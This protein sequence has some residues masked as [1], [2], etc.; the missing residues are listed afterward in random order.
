MAE[1]L[2]L[3]LDPCAGKS[4][5]LPSNPTFQSFKKL[6]D[7]TNKSNGFLL[8]N[9][10]CSKSIFIRLGRREGKKKNHN[11]TLEKLSPKGWWHRGRR[12]GPPRAPSHRGA[13]RGGSG[14]GA[15]ALTPLS[16]QR[17]G[18]RTFL[19]EAAVPRHANAMTKLRRYYGKDFSASYSRVRDSGEAGSGL[20]AG[21]AAGKQPLPPHRAQLEP[22][23]LPQG[24]S[25]P[26]RC[27][28]Q[29][30]V[31]ATSRDTLEAT[32]LPPALPAAP[33]NSP[34]LAR[35]QG[36]PSAG[37]TGSPSCQQPRAHQAGA[38]AARMKPTKHPGISP[39]HRVLC[40]IPKCLASPCHHQAKQLERPNPATDGVN[41]SVGSPPSLS[42]SSG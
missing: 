31:P 3:L 17:F 11:T 37:D 41:P 38:P 36:P 32:A 26:S 5:S 30:Q 16:G 12:A 42:L 15:P 1:T 29:Q 8:G 27:E 33:C 10:A 14:H 25:G 23:E 34:S 6:P 13:T 7:K 24:T 39:H 28:T 22:A 2:T 35:G 40:F 9:A 19:S 4:P 20:F 21:E 18:K